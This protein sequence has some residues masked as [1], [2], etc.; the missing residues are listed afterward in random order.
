MNTSLQVRISKDLKE[1]FQQVAKENNKD[2]S[3]LIRDWIS[4]YVAKHQKPDEEV[5]A[6]IYMAGYELQQVLGGREYVSKEFA[7]QLQEYSLTDQ[8]QFSQLVLSTYLDL[9][10]T[11]PSIVSKTYQGFA[12]SQMFLLGLVGD[13]PAGFNEKQN[14][15]I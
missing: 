6:E 15:T 3:T 8:K 10:L 2:T 1:R 4:S 13:K 7:N 5:A 14:R 9:E 11:V 12:Y